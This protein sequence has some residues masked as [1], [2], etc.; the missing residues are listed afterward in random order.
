MWLVVAPIVGRFTLAVLAAIVAMYFFIQLAHEMRQ[1]ETRHFD[2]AVL[3][4]LREHRNPV[5]FQ[6]MSW[7]SW[8][9]SAHAQPVCYALCILGLIAARR[10][11][12][13]GLT[14]LVAGAGGGVLMWG[15]KR[16]FHRPRPEVAFDELGYSF[17]S[18]HTFFGVTLYCMLA[19]WL[20]RDAPPRRRTVIWTIAILAA[21][22]MGFSRI[23]LGEHFP[24]DVAAGFA[25]G[26]PWLWGCL[27]LPK[28][29]HRG[30]RDVST[31][32]KKASYQAGAARLRVAALHLPHLKRLACTLARDP[33][34]PRPRQLALWV[35]AGYTASPVDLIP[36][37]IPLLGA[38][39]DFFLAGFVLNWTV[40]QVPIEVVT[41]AWDGE[42]D[43]FQVL[44]DVRRTLMDLWKRG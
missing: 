35:L 13:D 30:G 11:W 25:I 10:F 3:T 43:L 36:D 24:S 23:Y 5:L 28:A 32:E 21:L 15:L 12:P 40:K 39:D 17:P 8:L 19:Y 37:F 34:V 29:F 44:T 38:A 27:A 1:G 7:V 9:G 14:M 33:Q 41:A 2:V 22:L 20:A 42:P 4:F 26:L 31:E 18:G 6:V 16:L